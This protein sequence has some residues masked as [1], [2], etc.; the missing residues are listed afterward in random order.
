[1]GD[2]TK[3]CAAARCKTIDDTV[4]LQ[5]R[6]AI[7]LNSRWLSAANMRKLRFL[8]IGYH[9]DGGDRHDIQKRR[10]GRDE[11]P[12]ADLPITNNPVDRCAHLCVVEINPREVTRGLGLRQRGNG[13]VALRAEHAKFL[14]LRVDTG[15]RSG[16]PGLSAALPCICLIELALTYRA[17]LN[18]TAMPNARLPCEIKVRNRRAAHG[19]GL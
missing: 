19:V 2:Q 12:D 14:A 7:D 10:P 3:C 1:G 18:E 16:S 6:I 4:N 8:E 13:D 17:T 5:V 9:I 15:R 11:T